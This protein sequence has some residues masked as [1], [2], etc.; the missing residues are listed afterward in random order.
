DQATRS[1]SVR[2]EIENTGAELLMPGATATVTL[3]I[4][5]QAVSALKSAVEGAVDRQQQ[6]AQG[7]VL[8]VPESAV[9]ATG[10][11]SIVYR[12]STPG[13]YDGT[14]VA[15]GPQM[16]GSDGVTFYPVLSG[17]EPGDRVVTSGSFL[18]DAETR[19]NPAAGSIYYGGGESSPRTSAAQTVRPST[20]A[21]V[22]R[23]IE[24]ALAKLPSADR[25]AAEAQQFCAVLHDSRLGSM[26]MPV[27]VQ[28][29]GKTVFLCCE[30]CVKQAKAKPRE[31]LE[32]LE[33]MKTRRDKQT[34]AGKTA[35]AGPTAADRKAARIQASL[36]QLA[37]EERR[38]AETQRECPIHEGSLLGSMGV[39]V[40][41]S[42]DGQSVFICC[43]SC[44]E[45]ALAN[46]QETLQ[47]V[48][49]LR[50]RNAKPKLP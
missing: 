1:V 40:Q 17:L 12:E 15:L 32:H 39:P 47:K 33:Q 48:E 42:I 22:D 8:A 27:K 37:P 14:L 38:T 20:P 2:C 9:I 4:E 34:P 30:N 24:A 35:P 6:L 10:S 29:E 31:T 41:L 21:D 3:E 5:P 16:S 19:L 7:N 36:A 49:S 50:M 46:P 28:I 18:V 23:T 25:A 43:E 45:D 13:V 44:Q 26:G 11:Q